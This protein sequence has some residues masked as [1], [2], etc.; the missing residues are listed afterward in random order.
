MGARSFTHFETEGTLC[1]PGGRNSCRREA[2]GGV[3]DDS[4]R[5][6]RVISG[7][8]LAAP[9]SLPCRASILVLGLAASGCVTREA[10]PDSQFP[11]VELVVL[12]FV[13]L[14]AFSA[15]AS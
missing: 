10:R 3:R 15:L 13:G 6:S 14:W 2:G 12:L 5:M 1:S 8:L 11:R 9:L 7:G 4:P